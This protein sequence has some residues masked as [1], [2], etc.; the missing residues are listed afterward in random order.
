MP[1][2]LITKYFNI[3]NLVRIKIQS[4]LY[5]K[6]D[7]ILHQLREFE[8]PFLDDKDIDIFIKDY[9]KCPKIKN[10]VVLSEYYYYSNNYLN[11]PTEKYC[12][13]FI[14]IP[15]VIYCDGFRI[16][17]NFL[18]ELILLRKGYSLIHSAAAEYQERCCLFPSF[19]GVGKTATIS[20]ILFNA[21]KLFGDDMTIIKTREILSYPMD[22]SVYPYHLDILKIKDK[23]IKYRFKKTRIL[24]N[25]TNALKRYNWKIGKLLILIINSMKTLC[26]NVPP[27]DIFGT[28]CIVRKGR[29]DEVYYLS[30]EENSL[31]KI[32]IVNIDSNNLAE[33][34]TNILFQEWYQSM[35]FLYT[36]SG[37]SNFSLS[38]L[39]SE[40]RNIFRDTFMRYNCYQIKIPNSLDNL[41]Y[42]KQ[43]IS[44]LNIK[45]CEEKNNDR[46]D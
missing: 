2:K 43:L 29:I 25:I 13:N 8:E 42:Q 12:F 32:A 6:I 44:Y 34:C 23:R 11:I 18:V 46:R 36:Y 3:H 30:K 37:L 7:E 21:G 19:G 24:N 15:L 14:D 33:I 20:S 35:R 26:V 31:S 41:T 45:D 5:P 39:F 28:N 4:R 17:L 10:P 16:P 40:I 9:S 1:K 22:F 27:K 38:S